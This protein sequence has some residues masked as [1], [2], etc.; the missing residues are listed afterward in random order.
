MLPK[1]DIIHKTE[2]DPR[3]AQYN[4]KIPI[5]L[6]T[7]GVKMY[8]IQSS[9]R[10]VPSSMKKMIARVTLL[11]LCSVCVPGTCLNENMTRLSATEGEGR[12]Q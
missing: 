8:S 1:A 3:A 5:S 4:I 6:C 11:L 2:F 12:L 9:D 10:T 7:M